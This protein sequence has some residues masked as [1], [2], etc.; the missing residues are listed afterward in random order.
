MHAHWV[1]VEKK[2][3]KGFVEGILDAFLCVLAES[4]KKKQKKVFR[5][6]PSVKQSIIRETLNLST[7]AD[8]SIK[9]KVFLK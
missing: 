8:S 1:E 6:G 9:T 3:D 2:C 7:C 5:F 4:K